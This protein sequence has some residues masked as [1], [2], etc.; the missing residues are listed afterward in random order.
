MDNKIIIDELSIFYKNIKKS[1]LKHIFDVL[2]AQGIQPDLIDWYSMARSDTDYDIML[3]YIY[4]EYGL[5]I[6]TETES[7]NESQNKSEN[8][9]K[10]DLFYWKEIVKEVKSVAVIGE[11][12]SGK[13][14]FCHRILSYF[15]KYANKEIYVLN[16]PKHMEAQHLGWKILHSLEDMNRL[17][18]VVLYID[19][20]QHHMRFYENKGNQMLSNLLSLARQKN[21]TLVIST[22]VSQFITRMLE[23]QIDAW[24]I[25]DCDYDTIKQ[26]GRVR[27]IIKENCTLDPNGFRLQKNEYLFYCRKFYDRYRGR[28]T[29]ELPKYWNDNHSNPYRQI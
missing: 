22:A 15:R 9:K 8:I 3:A 20:P 25:K 10:D 29:F 11:T 6:D 27:K 19:E 12:G 16:H 4:E 2:E 1:E 26:G 5:V 28:F 7:Q 17:Q 21:I 24:V 13:T 18:D 14:A 23:G